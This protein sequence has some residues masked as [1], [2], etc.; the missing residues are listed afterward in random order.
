M[1]TLEDNDTK[2]QYIHVNF[3]ESRVR[4]YNEPELSKESGLL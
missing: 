1:I 2:N 3:G 4:Q